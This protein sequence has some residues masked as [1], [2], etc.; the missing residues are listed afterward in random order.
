MYII[1]G[2]G[3]PGSKYENTRHNAGFMAIDRLAESKGVDIIKNKFNSLTAQCE[4]GGEKVLLMKP[5]TYMNNSGEAIEEARA[6]FKIPEE[7]VIVI[8]DDITQKPGK[9]RI[10]R[11]GSAG[12]HNGLKSIIQCVG[13]D[14]FPRIRVGVGEKPHPDADLISHVLGRFSE[15]E[16]KELTVALDNAAKAAELIVAGDIAEAMNRYN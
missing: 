13:T 14:E 12:G 4:I 5:L 3:N 15:E 10:R 11:K 1:A 6:F 16:M 2:L 8:S 7:N 9:L